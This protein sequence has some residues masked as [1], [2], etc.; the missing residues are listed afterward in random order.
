[1]RVFRAKPHAGWTFAL[2]LIVLIAQLGAQAHAY[3]HMASA[4]DTAQHHVHPAPCVE[5]STFAPLLAAVSSTSYAAV[6]GGVCQDRVCLCLTVVIHD[7]Q[8]FRANRSRAP[9]LQS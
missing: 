1:L 9:P 8:V 5:C 4:P 3:T 2:A 7:A 6:P